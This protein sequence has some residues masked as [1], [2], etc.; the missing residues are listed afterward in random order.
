MGTST[1]GFVQ[2]LLSVLSYFKIVISVALDVLQ[3]IKNVQRFQSIII[4][5][6]AFYVFLTKCYADTEMCWNW[7]TTSKRSSINHVD[8]ILDICID[9]PSPLLKMV[10]YVDFCES[11]PFS[12]SFKEYKNKN[13][14]IK[15][16]S[17]I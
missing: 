14:N 2:P 8:K 17:L 16:K 13:I 3:S 11:P 7:L 10:N 15:E 4:S 12:K 5:S 9:S 6:W 1:I